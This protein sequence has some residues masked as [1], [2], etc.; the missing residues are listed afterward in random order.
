MASID[1]C[2]TPQ[3]APRV[4]DEIWALTRA[5]YD[6]DRGYA[7][8]R[9]KEHQRIA[10]FRA[11]GEQGLIGMASM[12]V[13]PLTFRGRRL[14]VIFTSHVLLREQHRGRNLI[15]RLGLRTFL[16][17]RLR[18]PLRPIYWFFDTFSCKSYLLLS[19]NL[20]EYWPRHDRPTPQWE[21]A[22]MDQLAA[23]AY[24]A[25]WLPQRGVVARS[26][27]KR[28]RPETAPLGNAGGPDLEFFARA[29]P[30]H[31]E[32]D[33]LA[34]LCPLTAGNWLSVGLRALRREFSGRG[35]RYSC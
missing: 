34:C 11:R 27:K 3:I 1:V 9:L 30:G 23:Q 20:R 13:Y 31:A 18:Y 32:G 6:T 35:R 24:G 7:E 12:D 25:A 4:W 29:N 8:G 17:A 15:Q 26:G 22:L 5:Y 33:M 10:L 19:R 21:R 14:A 2:S 16:E 28:L